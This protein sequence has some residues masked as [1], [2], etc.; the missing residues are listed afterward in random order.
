ML[1]VLISGAGPTGLTLA[2]ELARRGIAFR[3]IEATPVHATS[4]RGKGIQPRTLEVFEHLGILEEILESGAPYPRIRAHVWRFSFSLKSMYPQ[5][6]PTPDVPWPDTWM[7]PQWRTEAILRDRLAALGGSVE[8]GTR[9]TGFTQSAD[10]VIA[11]VDGGEPIEARYLVGADGGH[12]TVRKQMGVRF[13]GE[14]VSDVRALVGD[15]EVPG[16]DRSA[17]H[18]WPLARGC[19]LT[20]CPMPGSDL[21]QLAAPLRAKAPEPDVSEASVRHF[22]ED[23]IGLEV[24]RAPWTSLYRPHVRMVDR[25]RVGRVFLAGDAA[26]VHPASGGQ[27]LNTGVQDG[28]NLGWKLAHVLGGAP[29]ALLDSYEEERRPVAASVLGLSKRLLRERKRGRA[30]QQLDLGYRGSALAV[31]TGALGGPLRA[32]DRAP[33]APCSDPS[34]RPV[35]LF[36]RMSGAESTL[37][38]FGSAVPPAGCANAIRIPGDLVDT[39]GHARSAYGVRD[40]FVLVRPDHYVG[41]VTEDVGAL[42]RY[43]ARIRPWPDAQVNGK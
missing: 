30:S 2:C 12:S 5:R 33:D 35:R 37:L 18:V 20:L 13:E 10:S 19:I 26:H 31:E 17:W 27:G 16:L 3:L 32:G 22:V 29:D 42:E 25:F 15:V 40:G 6:P 4:S 9:L 38:A 36:E 11:T 41:I 8:L 43:L 14:P 21:F 1:P 7:V 34:G 24:T 28:Y 39:A 23:R